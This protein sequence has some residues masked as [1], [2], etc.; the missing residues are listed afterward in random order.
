MHKRSSGGV[1]SCRVIQVIETKVVRGNGTMENPLRLVTQYW[2]FESNLLAEMDDFD[3]I[4]DKKGDYYE[5]L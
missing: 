4:I 2:D 1:E 3:E 5:R